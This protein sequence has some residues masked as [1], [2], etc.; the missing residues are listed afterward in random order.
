[1]AEHETPPGAP[2]CEPRWTSSRKSGVGTA[3]SGESAVWFTVAHGILNEIYFPR[4]DCANT[5]D[6][7]L[8]VSAEGGFFSEEK[9]HAHHEIEPLEQGVPGYRLTNTCERGRYRITKI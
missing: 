3:M 4:I 7:G 9:R 6:V 1:M 2:G 5:R 8:L